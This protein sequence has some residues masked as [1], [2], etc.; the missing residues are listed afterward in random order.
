[1]CQPDAPGI[2]FPFE[3][4][5]KGR[6]SGWPTGKRLDKNPSG[7]PE[8]EKV[9][10]ETAGHDNLLCAELDR[11]APEERTHTKPGRHGRGEGREIKQPGR[12]AKERPR[13]HVT[14]WLEDGK[15]GDETSDTEC[16]H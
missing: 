5:F 15:S 9:E 6:R 14:Q 11:I 3:D 4:G 13:H 12:T 1:P 7:S 8:I 2:D 16:S 10:N